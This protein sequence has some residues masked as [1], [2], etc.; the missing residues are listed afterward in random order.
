MKL[1]FVCTGNICR[2]PMAE[3]LLRDMM[4]QED[5]DKLEVASAGV[6]ATRGRPPSQPAV[7]ALSEI[8]IDELGMHQA[9]PVEQVELGE[10][11]LLLT[12]T[13]PHLNL[14]PPKYKE[15]P[16][17]TGLLKEYVGGSGNISDP[18]GAG[19]ETYRDL[20]DDLIPILESLLERLRERDFQP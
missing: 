12:M 1:A 20:R 4:S 5:K 9:R 13:R 15:G 19:I 16:V 17:E 10:G 2:S 7:E 3:Y 8:G 14:L 11:D 6:T 18:Y